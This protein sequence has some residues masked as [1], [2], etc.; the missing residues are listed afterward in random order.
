M[1]TIVVKDVTLPNHLLK[2]KEFFYVKRIKEGIVEFRLLLRSVPTAVTS[3]FVVAVFAMNILANKSITLNVDWLA[4]DTGIIV[5]WVAF[6]C[7]DILTKHFGPKASTQI[8]VFAI[9]I[10]LVMCLLLFVASKIKGDWGAYFDLGEQKIVNDGLDITFGG[11]WYV[12]VGSTVAFVASAIINNFINFAIGK[13]FKRNPDAFVAYA[14]RTYV[15][16][17]IG[18]F[19]DNLI[20]ALIVSHFFFDWSI[21]QCLTCAVT[22]MLVEL[23]C[24]AIFSPLGFAVCKRW[25]REN[26]GKEF[27]EYL[28]N[29]KNPVK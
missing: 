15:S 7:M 8:S 21:V 20:F 10:N 25:K 13:L 6:L 9:V 23:V 18:Q 2:N 27:F 19:A 28:D 26:V 12:V 22:G 24:E 14:C 4:L 17:A 1:Y 11:T 3:I 29:R 16:T 5:S